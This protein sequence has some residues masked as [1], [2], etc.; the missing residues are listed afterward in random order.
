MSEEQ[1]KRK[2]QSDGGDDLPPG[3]V[4]RH[5][6]SK[7]RS[8][9]F[10]TENNTSS[11][12]R[13][14]KD[15]SGE[16]KKSEQVK[17][18]HILIKHRESRRPSSWKEENITRTSEEA[19]EKLKVIQR[20]IEEEGIES[21]D[22]IAQEESDCSSAKRGGDLGYFGRGKMQKPFEDAAFAL[23]VNEMSKEIVSTESGH[24]IILRTA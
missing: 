20:Q 3:W 6:K 14:R 24:H 23:T 2:R 4:K 12:D 19:L 8:Y 18:S 13:P 9:Y 17:A 5:S 21:F 1:P 22:K 11:W 7:N 15:T 16:E 10:N